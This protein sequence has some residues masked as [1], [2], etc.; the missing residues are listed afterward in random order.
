ML[1]IQDPREVAQIRKARRVSCVLPPAKWE[2][3]AEATPGRCLTEMSSDRPDNRPTHS[4]DFGRGLQGRGRGSDK[5]PI[6]VTQGT[7]ERQKKPSVTRSFNRL[8]PASV[9]H[10]RGR[11]FEP[12]RPRHTFQKSSLEWAETIEGAKGHRFM[13][14]LCPF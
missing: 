7:S 13:S 8:L 9:C 5:G 1:G 3:P 6:T 10:G 14:L 4:L 12:R 11:G 2:E